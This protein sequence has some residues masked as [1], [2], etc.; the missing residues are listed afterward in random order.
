MSPLV[1][2]RRTNIDQAN[3]S[4]KQALCII[5]CIK[6]RQTCVWLMDWLASHSDQGSLKLVLVHIV[7]SGSIN[8]LPMSGVGGLRMLAETQ[9]QVLKMHELLKDCRQNILE[10]FP[11]VTVEL[12]VKDGE[13][14]KSVLKV[15]NDYAADRLVLF[16]SKRRTWWNSFAQKFSNS[17]IRKNPCPVD[18]VTVSAGAK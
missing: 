10:R 9:E 6:D 15:I 17:I 3:S 8:D 4:D 1:G 11:A 12:A 7:Y 14:I 18:I 5:A 13:P 16:V 2:S